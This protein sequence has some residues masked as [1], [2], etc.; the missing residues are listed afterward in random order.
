MPRLLQV[1]TAGAWK[2]VLNLR[3]GDARAVDDIK[4]AV[5]LLLGATDDVTHFRI[6]VRRGDGES[7]VAWS[8]GLFRNKKA[9]P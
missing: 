2:N 8:S 5:A 7:A 4:T 6:V 1:N 9:Q 3:E